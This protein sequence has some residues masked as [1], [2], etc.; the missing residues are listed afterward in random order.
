MSETTNAPAVTNLAGT[1]AMQTAI[2]HMKY[3]GTSKR[4]GWQITMA[5]PSHPKT[6]ALG[7]EQTRERLDKQARIEQVQVNGR[8]WKVED[9]E[10]EDDRLR[11]V[12]SLVGRI[13]TWTPIDLGAGPVEFSEQ[14]A[15]DLLLNPDY[16]HYVA[17][18]TD[19]LLAEGSFIPDSAKS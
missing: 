7:N 4:N 13:V 1:A 8:K 14:A 10:P 9:V 15:I 6:I 16:G 3:P 12:R 5:G 11:F 17:Q 19:F 2:L 18:I